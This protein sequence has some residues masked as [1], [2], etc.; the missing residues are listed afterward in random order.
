MVPDENVGSP[1]PSAKNREG[2]LIAVPCVSEEEQTIERHVELRKIGE[3]SKSAVIFDDALHIPEQPE[4]VFTLY[5]VGLTKKAPQFV[6]RGDSEFRPIWSISAYRAGAL[7]M[8]SELSFCSVSR[9]MYF[10]PTSRPGTRYRERTSD[11]G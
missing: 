8:R 6:R 1:D 3:G 9:H 5:A 2:K 4:T 7:N 11:S 10:L